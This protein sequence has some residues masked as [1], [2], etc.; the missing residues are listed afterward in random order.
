MPGLDLV[1]DGKVDACDG[2]VPNIMVALTVANETAPVLAQ[3][4]PDFLFVLRHYADIPT[5]FQTES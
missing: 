1:I 2:T 3:D 4:V 5:V